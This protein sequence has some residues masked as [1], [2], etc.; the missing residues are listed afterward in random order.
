MALSLY[1]VS[2]GNPNPT[3]R[4]FYAPRELDPREAAE[5]RMAI[6]RRFEDVAREDHEDRAVIERT[7]IHPTLYYATSHFLRSPAP[8]IMRFRRTSRQAS[9]GVCLYRQI[10][11]SPFSPV[12]LAFA[13]R[14]IDTFE[15]FLPFAGISRF[16]WAT[17][18]GNATNRPATTPLN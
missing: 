14:C 10:G 6:R 5:T 17:P 3:T 18:A 12:E 13:G 16:P 2:L 4:V 1:G 7:G 11:K 8:M 15:R 9:I